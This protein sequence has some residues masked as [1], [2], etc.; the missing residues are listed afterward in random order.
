MLSPFLP[1]RSTQTLC[2]FVPAVLWQWWMGTFPPST[3]GMSPSELANQ[4]PVIKS[5]GCHVISFFRYRMYMWNNIFFSYAFDGRDHYKKF[6]GDN[7]AR[8][9]AVSHSMI[10]P[11][12]KPHPLTTHPRLRT[13]RA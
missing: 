9:A 10:M 7:A 3:Q 6:G 2:K 11:Y 4:N 5:H 12:I 13:C 1:C 8:A